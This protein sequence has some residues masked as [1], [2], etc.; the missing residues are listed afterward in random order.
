MPSDAGS[1]PATSIS[2]IDTILA[3]DRFG[4]EIP[5]LNLLTCHLVFKKLCERI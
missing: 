1:I 5:W 4:R 3:D 2:T